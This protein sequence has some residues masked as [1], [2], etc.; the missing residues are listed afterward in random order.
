MPIR[1]FR[2]S[3]MLTGIEGPDFNADPHTSARA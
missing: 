1:T 3:T 2:T